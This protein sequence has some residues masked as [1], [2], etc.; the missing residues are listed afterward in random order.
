MKSIFK[1]APRIR[2]FA[3]AAGIGA[4]LLALAPAWV[5]AQQNFVPNTP[6]VAPAPAVAA[7]F[8]LSAPAEGEVLP[9][10]MRERLLAAVTHSLDRAN[11]GMKSRLMLAVANPFFK[12]L[13]PAPVAPPDDPSAAM[14][15]TPA[16]PV[17]LSD[18]DKLSQL[19]DQLKPTGEV[20]IG[21]KHLI[22][23]P[24][25]SIAVGQSFTVT[26]PNE[27]TPTSILVEAADEDTYTL[28][29]NDTESPFQYYN[30]PGSGNA[31][32]TPLA[33]PPPPGPAP[34][35]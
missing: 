27:I 23:T 11:P 4:L 33:V 22:S 8:T 5:L 21:Q 25:G 17:K 26:F 12:P 3:P 16:A 15:K 13:P 34:A 29:L 31:A 9:A 28:K 30:Q 1:S 7:N 20:I 32:A 2:R 19:N 18:A 14:S 35:H 6:P 24:Q 10:A